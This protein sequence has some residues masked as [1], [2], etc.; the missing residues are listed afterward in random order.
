M[1]EKELSET[2]QRTEYE[3]IVFR[4]MNSKCS[5]QLL[6]CLNYTWPSGVLVTLLC[7]FVPAPARFFSTFII[8]GYTNLT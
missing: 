2:E 1:H 7:S 6:R 3:I 8:L 5:R 4:P